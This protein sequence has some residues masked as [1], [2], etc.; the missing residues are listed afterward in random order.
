MILMGGHRPLTAWASLRPSI[1]PGIS[2]SVK[3]TTPYV[4]PGLKQAD[5]LV[6]VG[7]LPAPMGVMELFRPL[8][9]CPLPAL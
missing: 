6:G 5:R 2:T 8:N 9:F 3:T 7:T 4:A 1:E